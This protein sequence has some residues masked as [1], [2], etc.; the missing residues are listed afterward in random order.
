MLKEAVSPFDLPSAI[1]VENP[2]GIIADDVIAAVV[3]FVV[4]AAVVSWVAAGVEVGSGFVVAEVVS[5]DAAFVSVAAAAV[6]GAAVV[7]EVVTLVSE[8]EPN[9][10]EKVL[11][12]LL[13]FQNEN[14]ATNTVINRSRIRSGLWLCV[15]DLLV[16]ISRWPSGAILPIC[17]AAV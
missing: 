10:L 14:T 8:D 6:V 13:L 12:K 1:V 17:C 16:L 9:K 11:S 7:V 15:L 3:K 2:E 4:S 5:F